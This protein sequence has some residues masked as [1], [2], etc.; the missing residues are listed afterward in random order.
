MF[1][2]ST[3]ALLYIN[4]YFR[5]GS[6]LS[7]HNYFY[8]YFQEIG[9]GIKKASKTLP[10]ECLAKLRRPLAEPRHPMP[11]RSSFF[12]LVAACALSLISGEIIN[13][14]KHVLY[15]GISSQ[16]NHLL[17][18]LLEYFLV[19]SKLYICCITFCLMSHH[20]TCLLL[21]LKIKISG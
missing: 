3:F 7:I 4:L 14:S 8:R 18:Y 10:V 11:L 9:K 19:P 20:S 1:L 2:V 17:N 12:C 16:N 13:F 5:A 6:A 15:P 21:L